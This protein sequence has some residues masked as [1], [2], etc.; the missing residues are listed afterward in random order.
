MYWP[1]PLGTEKQNSGEFSFLQRV[2][3]EEASSQQMPMGTK[4]SM[5]PKLVLSSQ[6][7]RKGE[8]YKTENLKKF[9]F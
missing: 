7:A 1:G 4:P 6:R 8:A 2:R 9:F 5:P 3:A